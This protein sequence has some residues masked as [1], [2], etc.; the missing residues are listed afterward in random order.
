MTPVREQK[1]RKEYGSDLAEI[2]G[3]DL[4]SARALF[5]SQ[6]GRKENVLYLC[7]QALEK[8]L[9]GLLCALDEPI[10]HTHDL[11]FLSDRVGRCKKI[12]F[13]YDLRLLNDFA[14]IRRY[15]KGFLELTNDDLDEVL[16]L[17]DQVLQWL[18]TEIRDLLK[19]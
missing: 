4:E 6:K 8:G 16:K 9:K 12:P 7:Q 18:T 19:T 14:A 5:L 3:G 1:Y 10:P 11:V 2:A 15:E 17:S 13:D